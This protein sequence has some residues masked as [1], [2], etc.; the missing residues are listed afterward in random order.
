M[1]PFLLNLLADPADLRSPLTFDAAQQQLRGSQHNYPVE[2]G[3]PRL[4][5]P[6]AEAMVA[7]SHHHEAAATSFS[8]VDHYSKD[9]EHFDYFAPY[10]DG[11][12]LHE[13][14][15]LHES[16][17]AQ[18]PLAT[19]GPI[20]DVG[21]GSAWVAG[22]FSG[23]VTPVV[24]FDISS[25]NTRKAI[26]LYPGE[27]HVAVMGDVYH[28]PFR[29]NSFAAII[30]AEVI[31]HVPN[32]QSYL[33]NL[34]RVV[35][36]GGRI[37]LSTPYDE[38][39]IYSLCIHCNRPTPQH[40]HLHVFTEVS[41]SRELAQQK[42]ITYSMQ[43][44]SNKALLRLRTYVLLQYLPFQGWRLLDRWANQLI[45]KPGRLLVVIEKEK[46]G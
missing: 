36:P 21:S 16:I 14:R 34:I 26:S 43:A 10:T 4:L 35:K 27:Q 32:I 44:I 41:M 25:V 40:A 2:E 45:R 20:L 12:T 6:E 15:R 19:R 46:E 7:N 18:L 28:L 31:E 37:I 13:Q 23:S 3:V 29:E 5:L 8:Y 1:Q 30:S 38:K 9:G 22:H 39:I 11:A 33:T 17:L 24:S 42:G